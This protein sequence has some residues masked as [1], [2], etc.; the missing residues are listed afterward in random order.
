L[1]LNNECMY[2]CSL[3]VEQ[4]INKNNCHAYKS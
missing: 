1:L 4:V 3:K 2:V